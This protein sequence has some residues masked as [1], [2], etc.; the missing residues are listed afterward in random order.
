M[1]LK[2][3][4]IDILSKQ[5]I[6]IG[7]M[8][9]N[10]ML[11]FIILIFTTIILLKSNPKQN[12]TQ[13]FKSSWNELNEIYSSK[14]SK[15]IWNYIVPPSHIYAILLLFIGNLLLIFFTYIIHLPKIGAIIVSILIFIAVI[16]SSRAAQLE[17]SSE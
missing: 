8:G 13:K 2:F 5:G 16:S 6:N 3:G 11:T 15:S 17:R 10:I 7:F 4:R 1:T 12:M 14:K 9:W